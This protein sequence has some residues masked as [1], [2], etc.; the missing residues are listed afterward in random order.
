[1]PVHKGR[2]E[3]LSVFLQFDESCLINKKVM[4][5]VTFRLSGQSCRGRYRELDAWS[6]AKQRMNKCG[7]TCA[8][9][10]DNDKKGRFEESLFHAD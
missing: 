4:L 5:P 6:R 9:R 8:R 1:M 3:K 10:S 7:F 2:L